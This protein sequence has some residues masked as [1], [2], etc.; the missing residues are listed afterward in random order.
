MPSRDFK[1]FETLA[2]EQGVKPVQRFEDLLG[3]FWPE[4]EDIE[5]FL[6]TIRRWRQEGSRSTEL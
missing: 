5:E 1:D 6:A 4:D 3:D 2:K